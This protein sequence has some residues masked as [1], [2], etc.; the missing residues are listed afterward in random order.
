V[1]IYAQRQNLL[2]SIKFVSSVV[3]GNH[4]RP[5]LGCA[6]L[7]RS[8]G[9]RLV[10]SATDAATWASSSLDCRGDDLAVAIPCRLLMDVVKLAPEGEIGIEIADGQA[11]I[12]YPGSRYAIHTSPADTSPACPEVGAAEACGVPAGRLRAA[13]DQTIPCVSTDATR[14][15]I[16]GVLVKTSG[17]TLTLAATDTRRIAV[18]YVADVVGGLVGSGAVVPTAAAKAIRGMLWDDDAHATLEY[19]GGV[20]AVGVGDDRL[21]TTCIDGTFPPYQDI[22]DTEAKSSYEFDTAD[23]A[24]VAR[25]AV[26]MTSDDRPGVRLEFD[27]DGLT[28]QSKS[29]YAGAS[30]L[31][32]PCLSASGPAANV[33]INP[34]FLAM[35]MACAPIG[36]TNIGIAGPKRPVQICSGPFF[37]A[38]MPMELP[39]D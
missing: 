37:A 33:G 2:R 30:T 13:L 9:G 4:V 18:S 35:A 21:V 10:V 7:R 14:Y 26:L 25:R 17:R 1:K 19:A 29:E 6:V 36:K 3:P 39:N 24:S 20:L 5:V 22:I 15:A 23:I 16:N 12:T 32:C 11:V 31:T 38:I 8:G 28:I 27:S 34:R